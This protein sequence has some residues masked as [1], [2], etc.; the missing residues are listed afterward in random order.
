MEDN[1]Y[2]LIGKVTV[3]ADKNEEL[4]GYVLDLLLKCGIRKA[5]E[6]EIDGRKQ[7]V[8]ER[9]APDENGIVS[10]NYSIFE[11]TKR[12]TGAYDTN[13]CELQFAD[14]G[15]HEYGDVMNM[16]MALQEAY[17]DG[18]CYMMY[19]TQPFS[20]I[21]SYL[22]QIYS[23]TGKKFYLD[24]RARAFDMTLFFRRNA[25]DVTP[26]V[27]LDCLI[28]CVYFSHW[29]TPQANAFFDA[30]C[31]KLNHCKDE[32]KIN[33]KEQI[34]SATHMGRKEYL[35]RIIRG[36][37]KDND[38]NFFQYLSML[39]TSNLKERS[40]LANSN[41]PCGIVAEASLYMHSASVIHIYALVKDTDFWSIWDLLPA[42]KYGDVYT[43][44]AG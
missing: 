8:V 34:A 32:Y 19:G 17:S 31:K 39:V 9:P 6:I 14:C 11:K 10:F 20:S 21:S 5:E 4:N 15:Y 2:W 28:D 41:E 12:E 26:D 3:P 24:S 23:L 30:N 1:K 18:N 42:C 37:V 38:E 36:L 33:C 22:E 16:I 40:E 29:N 35:Y 43:V 7:T 25:F 13:T 27:I 44:E